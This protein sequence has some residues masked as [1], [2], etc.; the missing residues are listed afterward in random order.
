MT[1]DA[2]YALIDALTAAGAI[3]TTNGDEE[4]VTSIVYVDDRDVEWTIHSSVTLPNQ[5]LLS[6]SATHE[7]VRITCL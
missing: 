4:G 7:V 1:H 2:I 5:E 6:S 3:V